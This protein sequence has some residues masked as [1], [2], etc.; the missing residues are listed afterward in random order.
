MRRWPRLF[1]RR[2]SRALNDEERA[3]LAQEREQQL[4]DQRQ[5]EAFVRT[6]AEPASTWRSREDLRREDE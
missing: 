2:E 5:G 6:Y 4:R 3:L 1:R